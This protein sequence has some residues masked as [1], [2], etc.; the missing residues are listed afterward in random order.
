MSVYD[1]SVNIN[2][3]TTMS[4]GSTNTLGSVLLVDSEK[5][6]TDLL[7]YNLDNESF[8]VHVAN[9]AEEVASSDLTSYRLIIADAMEQSFTGRDLL[10][11]IKSNPLTTHIPVIL[12]THSDSE[13]DILAAFD[14][15]VD[16]YVFKPFSLRELI[17]RIKSVLRRHPIVPQ[18]HGG[19]SALIKAGP[20]ELDLVSRRVTDDGVVVP[21]TK[22]EFA[23]LALLMKNKP[24]FFNRR[25]I[26]CEVWGKSDR[27]ENDRTVDTNISRL[28]KKLG[29]S[30]SILVNRSGMGYAIVE[31]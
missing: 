10:R 25:Q 29:T 24:A 27:D 5:H 20:L 16:D 30:G 22:T 9:D 14:D 13:D 4:I 6:I 3:E 15:G 2:Q 31:A 21:L 1:R 19:P 26:Y 18:T 28:R 7:S 17:A 8:D 11:S 23:I 12:V